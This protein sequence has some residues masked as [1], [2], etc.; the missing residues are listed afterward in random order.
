MNAKDSHFH[1]TS[2][3][4][5]M[6]VWDFASYF[7]IYWLLVGCKVLQLLQDISVFAN[8]KYH[9]IFASI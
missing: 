7:N 4:S 2:I 6:W 3:K 5:K 9:I 1:V 8:Y